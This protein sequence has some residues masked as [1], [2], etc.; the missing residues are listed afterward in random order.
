M[1]E[2][3]KSNLSTAEQ[4]ESIWKLGGLSIKQFVKVVIQGINEDNLLGRAAELAF[5]LIL[6]IFP[7]MIC[8]LSIFGLFASHGSALLQSLFHYL[9]DALPPSAYKLFSKTVHEI[10]RSSGGGKLT[11]G[12][13]LSLWFASGGMSSM[14]ST[15]NGV[16]RVQDSRSFIKYRAIALALTIAIAILV[17]AALVLVLL[18]GDLS[19]YIASF[20]GMHVPVLLVH[21]VQWVAVLF[22]LSLSFSLIYYFGPDLKEQHWYWITPGS[23]IG[24]ILWLLASGGF[25]AY[26]HFFNTYSRTYGSLGAVMILLIW[27]YV[28]GLSFLLGGQVNA[29]IEHAAAMH[30]HPEAKAPGQKKAAE[31]TDQRDPH[32]SAA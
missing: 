3:T 30:G 21:I 15:L 17:V 27:L 10:A 5:N 23:I 19:N 26:L 6:A 28:A 32:R 16:Y 24:V 18:G 12:L 14:M 25:R 31:S 22:F 2:M 9:S 13:V 1:P 11:F 8:L 29:D 4:V 20:F 7:L